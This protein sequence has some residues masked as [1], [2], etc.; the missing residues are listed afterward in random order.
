MVLLF[1][2]GVLI[3]ATG[4]TCLKVAIC[5]LHLKYRKYS[6]TPSLM[7]VNLTETSSTFFNQASGGVSINSN[8]HMEYNN[9]VLSAL[10]YSL[11]L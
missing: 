10:S 9:N 6:R 1:A 3:C 5:R 2:G 7:L 8:I 4:S 11:Q